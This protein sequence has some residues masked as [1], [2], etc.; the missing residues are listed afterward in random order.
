MTYSEKLK[1]PKWQ[2]KRLEIMQRDNFKCRSCSSVDKQLQ[3]HHII[4]INKYKNPWDYS[5][6][7]LITLCEDCHKYESEENVN[8]SA[9][10]LLEKFVELTNLTLSR[11]ELI[12]IEEYLLKQDGYTDKEALKMSFLKLIQ[13][14]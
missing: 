1:S 7:F 3:I 11:L 14:V 2:K 6:E 5:N 4:Y 13:S 8:T 9:L 12:T 10:F